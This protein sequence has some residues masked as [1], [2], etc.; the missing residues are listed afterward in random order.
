MTH[1][2]P[3]QEPAED[4]VKQDVEPRRIRKAEPTAR[5]ARKKMAQGAQRPSKPMTPSPYDADEAARKLT[6]K[7][8]EKVKREKRR[9]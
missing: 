2:Y 5:A 3:G 9:P 4:Q 8:G 6:E 7:F 1:F